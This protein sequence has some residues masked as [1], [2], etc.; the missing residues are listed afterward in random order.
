MPSSTRTSLSRA[1]LTLYITGMFIIAIP[2]FYMILQLTAHSS[3]SIPEVKYYAN[4]LE[5]VIAGLTLLSCGCYL[6]ERVA[7]EN[8]KKE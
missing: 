6:T 8:K 4:A 2:L 3:L 1:T 5:H 7:R